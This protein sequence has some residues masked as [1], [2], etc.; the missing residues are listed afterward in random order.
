MNNPLVSIVTPTYNQAAYIAQTL[1]S[2]RNQV[3]RPIEHIVVDDSSTDA[4]PDILARYATQLPY[5][6]VIRVPHGGEAAAVNAGWA[7]AQGKY[8]AWLNSD[9]VLLPYGLAESVAFLEAHPEIDLVYRDMLIMDADGQ[10]TGE[11]FRAAPFDPVFTVVL[12]RRIS[13]GSVLLRQDLW[14][15]SS[16]IPPVADYNPDFKLWLQAMPLGRFAYLPGTAYAWRDQPASKN[17][18]RPPAAFFLMDY[19]LHHCISRPTLYPKLY[20]HK[21]RIM[22]HSAHNC[23]VACARDHN[24]AGEQF[25]IRRALWHAPLGRRKVYLALYALDAHLGT[26]LAPL[27]SALWRR[28]RQVFG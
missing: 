22:A 10:L 11:L 16:F 3:Y 15:R 8:L 6:R 4:T 7:I 14:A 23:A 25:F 17:R 26:R 9:D 19:M 27:T 28:L 1:E 12:N 2:V 21:R 24:P 18:N 5:L 13:V 20:A